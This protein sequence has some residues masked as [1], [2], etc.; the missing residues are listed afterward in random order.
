[1]TTRDDRNRRRRI[2]TTNATTAR[3]GA[4][5]GRAGQI[6]TQ[7]GSDGADVAIGLGGGFTVDGSGDIGV[8]VAPGVSVDVAPACVPQPEPS[9]A[10]ADP[11]C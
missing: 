7:L 1:M 9:S 4:T 8:R 5:G 3:T 11:G 6:P 10:P 2:T